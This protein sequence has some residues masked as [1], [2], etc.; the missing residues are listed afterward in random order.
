[1]A[2]RLDGVSTLPIQAN[3]VFR[4]QVWD[5]YGTD[6]SWLG[7]SGAPGEWWVCYHGT[8]EPNLRSILR[9]G[10]QIARGV[11]FLYGR[12]IYC[13]PNPSVALGYASNFLHKVGMDSVKC[14]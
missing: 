5:K 1:M 14:H 10:L 2:S 13:S 6:N 12:G 8:K 7:S 11:H 9:T 4:S 3:G